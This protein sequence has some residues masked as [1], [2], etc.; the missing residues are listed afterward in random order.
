M[1]DQV[2]RDDEEQ[3][4]WQAFVWFLRALTQAKTVAEV[5]AAAGALLQD[6]GEEPADE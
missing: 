1:T 5:N 2:A 4:Q 3:Q 6:L